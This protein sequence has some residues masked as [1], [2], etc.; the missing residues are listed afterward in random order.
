[1]T[2]EKHTETSKQ[3]YILQDSQQVQGV[4]NI[5]QIEGSSLKNNVASQPNAIRATFGWATLTKAMSTTER[6]LS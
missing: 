2:V 5:V 4:K 6:V 3:Q 1:M